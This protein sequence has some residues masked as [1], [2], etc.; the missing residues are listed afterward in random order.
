MAARGRTLLLITAAAPDIQRVRRARVLNFQQITMPY[1]AAFVPP[2]WNVI[3]IDEVVS[4]VDVTLDVDLVAITFHTPSAYHAYA[5][6]AQFRRRGIPVVAGGPHATLLPDEA[7]A[8][9]DVVFV[10]EAEQH[11]PRFLRDFENGTYLPRY[12]AAVSPTLDDAPMAR[13][14]LFHRRDLTGGRLFATRGCAYGCDFCTLAAMYQRRVRQRRVTDVAAEY[15]SFPG[16]VIIFWDDNLASDREYAKALFRAIAPYK[17][18]WSS[19]ASIQAGGD[20]EF[21]EWAARSGCKQLF[22]GLESISQASMNAVHKGFN[23]VEEYARVIERIHAHG[24]AVQAGIV[25]GFDHDSE[26]I[27]DE[28][29]D[30]LEAAGVQNATFNILTPY[31]GTRLYDRLE[32]EGRI[33]T[34]DWRR[35]N[36]RD[37]VVFKPRHMSPDMLLEGYRHAN[38]RFYSAGSIYRRLSRAPVGLWWTFPLNVAYALALQRGQQPARPGRGSRPAMNLKQWLYRGGR[39]N[40]LVAALNRFFGAVHA[41]GAAPNY[42]VTLDVRGRR[43]GRTISLPLVMAVV[44][45]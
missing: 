35:Y 20:P 25:F 36:G 12:A 4:P 9:A 34:H 6:A 21:L 27:F 40:R 19:Q 30:F 2:H 43:S 39:P 10:G 38:R 7:Q 15:A 3:H 18:W 5:L 29:L 45:G 26:T 33:L 1:L 8:H 13:K 17:K 42:L 22:I 28:T 24:I 41:L 31:P 16:K 11:W 23:R 14:E 44:D 37:S 32:A